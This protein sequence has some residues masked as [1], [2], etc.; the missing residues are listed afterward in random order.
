MAGFAAGVYQLVI[1][2]NGQQIAYK[3]VKA[4]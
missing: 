3:L 2:T 4:K 1:E